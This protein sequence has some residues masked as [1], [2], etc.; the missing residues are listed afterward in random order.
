M[1][2][3][4]NSARKNKIIRGIHNILKLI[5]VIIPNASNIYGL[6][7]VTVIFVAFLNTGNIVF[8]SKNFY[9]FSGVIWP[10]EGMPILLQYISSILPLTMATTSLR[11][12]LTRGWNLYEPDVYLGFISSITWILL[13]LTISMLVLKFKKG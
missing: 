8:I 6:I 9:S 1:C 12:I 10:V 7:L 13:F 2:A 11:S 3:C 5:T 4:S